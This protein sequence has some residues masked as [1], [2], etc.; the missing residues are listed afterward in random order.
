MIY[1]VLIHRIAPRKGE[2]IM[3]KQNRPDKQQRS[4]YKLLA[5]RRG[6]VFGHLLRELIAAARRNGARANTLEWTKRM[7]WRPSAYKEL[8]MKAGDK[9]YTNAIE[10]MTLT[11]NCNDLSTTDPMTADEEASFKRAI[12]SNTQVF[13]SIVFPVMH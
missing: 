8:M 7:I 1:L 2:N 3:K 4:D 11:V 12:K 10:M 5:T 6:F 13:K 9:A